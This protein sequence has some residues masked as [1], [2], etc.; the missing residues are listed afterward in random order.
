MEV[1][2]GSGQDNPVGTELVVPDLPARGNVYT[3]M[4]LLQKRKL[5]KTLKSPVASHPNVHTTHSLFIS[6]MKE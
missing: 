6:G 1:R 3:A 5:R 4:F 2:D